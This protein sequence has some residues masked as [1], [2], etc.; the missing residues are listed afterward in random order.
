MNKNDFLLKYL[1]P[2]NF[3][4]S[5]PFLLL[6]LQTLSCHKVARNGLESTIRVQTS[7]FLIWSFYHQTLISQLF[8]LISTFLSKMKKPELTNQHLF[9]LSRKLF[10]GTKGIQLLIEQ[11][12]SFQGPKPLQ[13]NILPVSSHSIYSFLQLQPLYPL[14]CRAPPRATDFRPSF[15]SPWASSPSPP[16][17]CTLLALVTDWHWPTAA[18]SGERGRVRFPGE[19]RR[20]YLPFVSRM[21]WLPFSPL[22]LIFEEKCEWI[23]NESPLH[24][25]S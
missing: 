5:G 21:I 24:Y 4:L 23:K 25:L 7:A 15:R 9:T 8:S 10:D 14:P 18:T 16:T 2:P 22:L 1:Q 11:G 17:L 13:Y 6:A 12:Q 20:C 3:L 19:S